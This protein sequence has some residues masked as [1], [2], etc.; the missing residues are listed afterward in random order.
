MIGSIIGGVVGAAGSI[1]GGITGSRAA[2]KRKQA[3]ERQKQKN[4]NW[5]D[6]RMNEDATQRADAQ[7]VLTRTEE[8]LRDRNSSTEGMAA[9]SGGTDESVAAAKAAN[10]KV[11]S[12]TMSQIAAK[13]ADDKDR[14][15][16]KYMDRDAQLDSQLGEIEAQRANAI[17]QAVQGVG[18]AASSIISSF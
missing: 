3:L 10:N 6:R 11:I 18:Q 4:Q 2:K 5:Y 1:F 14:I 7:R 8:M 13:A 12:D 16:Q 17:G 9:V 15:E